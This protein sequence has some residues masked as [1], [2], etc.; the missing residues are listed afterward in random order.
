MEPTPSK[1]GRPTKPQDERKNNVVGVRL[2]DELL[3][4]LDAQVITL[5]RQHRGITITR[6]D[7]IRTFLEHAL[8]ELEHLSAPSPAAIPP[9]PT[10]PAPAVVPPPPPQKPLSPIRQQIIECIR[11]H[12]EG[13]T[14][15][16]MQ[17]LLGTT[18]NLR[19]TAARMV[20]DGLLTRQANGVYVLNT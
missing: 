14:A 19:P 5:Q 18:A 15:S 4:R 20:E 17:K 12:P 8:P 1:R 13:L 2:D 6:A 16:Q 3:A 7:A 11:T 9:A 10:P